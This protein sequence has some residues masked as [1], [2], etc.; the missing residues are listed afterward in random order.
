[1]AY[2]NMQQHRAE[3]INNVGMHCKPISF[4]NVGRDIKSKYNV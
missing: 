3:I 1:M 4:D 2:D